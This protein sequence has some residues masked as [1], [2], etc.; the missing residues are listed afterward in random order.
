MQGSKALVSKAVER[1][2]LGDL[3][4][5]ARLRKRTP[6]TV[7][8]GGSFK[9]RDMQAEPSA[10]TKGLREEL[11]RVGELTGTHCLDLPPPQGGGDGEG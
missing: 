8:H 6:S 9:R 7:V 4:L 2:L 3:I 10:R 1:G 11:L 5:T